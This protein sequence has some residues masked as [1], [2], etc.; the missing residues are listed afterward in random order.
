MPVVRC[1]RLGRHTAIAS[2]QMLITLL[3]THAVPPFCCF[4]CRRCC[5]C[6]RRLQVGMYAVA[7]IVAAVARQH[8]LPPFLA[9]V[10]GRFGT[11]YISTILTGVAAAIIALFTDFADLVDM[12]SLGRPGDAVWIQLCAGLCRALAGLASGTYLDSNASTSVEY[13]TNL[14]T[15]IQYRY[16]EIEVKV[17]THKD[18]YTVS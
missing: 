5:C 1:V 8:M 14:T 16:I 12:V 3:N 15:N 11:P 2:S 9:K 13:V 10:H 6:C 7:R 4:C 18:D 17:E